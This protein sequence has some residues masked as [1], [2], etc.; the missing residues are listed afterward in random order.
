[1]GKD[2]DLTVRNPEELNTN[3]VGPLRCVY[4]IVDRDRAGNEIVVQVKEP[5]VKTKLVSYLISTS[6]D[7]FSDF[8]E[9]FKLFKRSSRRNL[10]LVRFCV[11]EDITDNLD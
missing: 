10:R 5:G 1:M 9:V 6:E 11:V 8:I 7:S 3:R 2:T 4:A